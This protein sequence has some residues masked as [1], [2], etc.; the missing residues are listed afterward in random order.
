M[1]I[2][3]EKLSNGGPE[4]DA[5]VGH[6][7]KNAS[8]I[9]KN[10]INDGSKDRDTS[11]SERTA[12]GT[13][14]NDMRRGWDSAMR[15]NAPTPASKLRSKISLIVQAEPRTINAAIKNLNI[16][17]QKVCKSKLVWYAAMVKPQAN[18]S[19]EPRNLSKYR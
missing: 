15:M 5:L 16:S 10:Q 19:C 12:L 4:C 2:Q 1:D 17:I 7:Q 9:L 14:Y 13:L 18:F 6:I 8:E 11:T 3:R